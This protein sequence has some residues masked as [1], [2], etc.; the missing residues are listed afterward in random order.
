[1]GL[2]QI[3]SKYWQNTFFMGHISFNAFVSEPGERF[4]QTKIDFVK[5]IKI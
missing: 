1:M 5:N 4:N 2:Q 3:K